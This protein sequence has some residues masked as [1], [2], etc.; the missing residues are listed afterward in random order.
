MSTGRYDEAIFQYTI[1]LSLKPSALQNLLGNRSR[2]RAGNGEW[3]DA[4]ND[5]NEVAHFVLFA[6]LY[7][8][9]CCSGN[10]ARHVLSIGIPET[11]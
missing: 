2:A 9:G 4:L 10:Q 7:A 6:F 3:E 11:A 1:A 8:N 5:A